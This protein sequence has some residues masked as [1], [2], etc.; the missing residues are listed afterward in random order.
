MNRGHADFSRREIKGLGSE[1][2][3]E[4]TLLLGLHKSITVCTSNLCELG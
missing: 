4:L 3:K 2:R 1:T